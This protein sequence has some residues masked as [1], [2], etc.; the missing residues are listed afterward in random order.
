MIKVPLNEQM[1]L[2]RRGVEEIIPE[3]NLVKKIELSILK[4]KPLTIKLGCDIAEKFAWENMASSYDK[5]L[6]KLYEQ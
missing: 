3:D 2:I 1:D 4:D 6:L 5:T